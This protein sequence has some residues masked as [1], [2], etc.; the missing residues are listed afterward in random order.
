M[1]NL[2]P[3]SSSEADCSLAE[4]ESID[5]DDD[6]EVEAEEIDDAEV[7]AEGPDV[8]DMLCDVRRDILSR[9]SCSLKPPVQRDRSGLFVIFFIIYMIYYV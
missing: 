2:L 5:D 3:S 1:R 8:E 9:R 4:D 6:A 7:E